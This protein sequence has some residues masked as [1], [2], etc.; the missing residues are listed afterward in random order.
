[1]PGLCASLILGLDFQ[2]RHKSIVFEYFGPEPSLSVCGLSTLNVNPPQP[3][4]NLSPDCRTIAAKTRRYSQEDLQFIDNE[5][6]SLLEEGI[7]EPSLSPWRAQVVVT[8]DENHKKRLAIDYSQA[9]NRYTLLDA[10]PLPMII[11]LVNKI[12]QYQVLRTI[13]LR[14]AHYQIPLKDD[15]KPYSAFEARNCL[16]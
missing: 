11:D 4:A 10:Y 9:I 3:F 5:V 13:D 14:S 8:K 1:M 12:A 16:Y 6:Q 2:S 15:D 7:I